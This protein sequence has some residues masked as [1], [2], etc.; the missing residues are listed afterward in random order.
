MTSWFPRT[1]P[2]RTA[3]RRR[4]RFVPW[5]ALL[6][7]FALA[8]AGRAADDWP[9][10]LGGAL[11]AYYA[12]DFA[13]ARRRGAEVAPDDAD[14]QREARLLEA[15]CELRSA[16][17]RNDALSARSRLAQLVR[18]DPGLGQRPECH[19]AY[20]VCQ[21]RL[22]ET[23]D[24]LDH[25]DRAVAGFQAAN[26]PA[27][28][29][30]AL[31]ATA[32]AW[33]VHG[34]WELL[35]PR[36]GAPPRPAPAEA[37]RIRRARMVETRAAAAQLPAGATAAAR[38]DVVIARYALA[39]GEHESAL[40][41]LE[42]LAAEAPRTVASTDAALLLAEQHEADARFA[43]ALPLYDRVAAGGAAAAAQLAGERAAEIRRPQCALN[44][45]RVVSTNAAADLQLRCR[46][47]ER[48][49]L[50]VRRIDL[51]SWLTERRG[52]FVESQL[53]TDG[54]VQLARSLVPQPAAPHAWWDAATLT[55]PV[56]VTA[57]AGAYVVTAQVHG[58]DGGRTTISRLL[59]VSDLRAT[60]FIGAREAVLWVTHAE[61]H[62]PPHPPRAEF[63]MHHSFVPTRPVFDGNGVAR[64]ALPAEARV[65]RDK[66]WACLVASGDHLAL[67]EGELGPR[68]SGAAE[69]RVALLGAPAAPAVGERFQ[70]VGLL[71][72]ERGPPSPPDGPAAVEIEV[73]DGL[74]RSYYRGAAAVTSADTFA[75]SVPIAPEM[76]GQDLRVVVRQAGQ[77]IEQVR[78]RF[79]FRVPAFDV[80]PLAASVRLPA[81]LPSDA[82]FL[83]GRVT[84]AYPWGTPAAGCS[85]ALAFRAVELTSTDW[86]A[87]GGA[88]PP[89]VMR[90]FLDE[91]GRFDFTFRL[92]DFPFASRPLAIGVWAH[93]EGWDER[94]A[95]AVA[96]TLAG[97]GPAFL[98][99]AAL[100]AVPAVGVPFQIRARWFDP[101]LLAAEPPRARLTEPDGR[102]HALRLFATPDG[103]RTA[104]WRPQRPGVHDVELMLTLRDGS[105]IGQRFAVEVAPAHDSTADADAVALSATRVPAETES[106]T[107]ADDAIEA[108]LQGGASGPLLLLAF[109]SEPWGAAVLPGVNGAATV[110]IPLAA[111]SADSVYVRVVR[112]TASGP[113]TLAE[114]MASDARD[115]D[116]ELRLDAVVCAAGPGEP[117][118]LSARCTRGDGTPAAASV[119]ARLMD[120]ADT[121]HVHWL[122]G[123]TRLAELAGASGVSAFGFGGAEPRPFGEP[124]ATGESAAAAARGDAGLE[125]SAALHEGGTL[126]L[127]HEQI[128]GEG[129]LRIERP[130]GAGPLRVVLIARDA[131]GRTAFATL[132]IDPAPGLSPRLALPARLTVGDRSTATLL[133]ENPKRE[134]ALV[135]VGLT[136][137]DTLH[138]DAV[139]AHALGRSIPV[140]AADGKWTLELPPAGRVALNVAVEAVR[141]GPSAL[142]AAI[143]CG[144]FTEVARARGDVHDP[145]PAAPAASVIRIRRTLL[146]MI[147]EYDPKLH[148]AAGGLTG[149][150]DP[151][152]RS[153][154]YE[155]LNSGDAIPVGSLIA[156]REDVSIIPPLSDPR[157]AAP[158]GPTW[159]QALP[160]CF[161]PVAPGS[162]PEHLIGRPGTPLLDRL[163]WRTDGLQPQEYRHE[164]AVIAV[165]P[166]VYQL[167]APQIVERGEA[168]GVALEPADLRIRVTDPQARDAP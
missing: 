25:L 29:A 125:L 142:R 116:A 126:A 120:A 77:V 130:A 165:R 7:A 35:D 94:A 60:G 168:L 146:R 110:H 38:I 119:V 67:C 154:S 9:P 107:S 122:P 4:S 21:T 87:G 37:D 86:L 18:D 69:P 137:S 63:W 109:G 30:A 44:V 93:V 89:I 15:L 10:E 144:A 134:R 97:D 22:F 70:L 62:P 6:V 160:P 98:A 166:G 5:G 91:A 159:S 129:T 71:W 1:F 123:Q 20:G 78:G 150:Y 156:V 65:L 68:A 47:V 48:I 80:T 133:L 8:D 39:A 59:L 127:A 49:D 161:V 163:D 45:P 135:T 41:T 152:R 167:A 157:F 13:E 23:A 73:L 106:N 111:P 46:N 17:G 162:V 151:L 148:D 64:F 81:R 139:R 57:A 11:A 61:A 95:Y 85:V 108:T 50:E 3:S 43:A 101:A 28:V 36:F 117:L 132:P 155:V 114:T 102:Q 118:T 92:T 51:Q 149:L 58:A 72:R 34:E 153:W 104:A 14:L 84:A 158:I 140:A 42:Q 90:G 75:T 105:T 145:S 138:V 79:S 115:P 24:A 12:D 88:S 113:H 16:V 33:A 19:L 112:L 76:A 143:E 128:A 82:A 99:G 96:K 31:V 147:A 136:P 40:L 55:E 27:R 74:G 83:S 103:P 124:T 54:G 131:A 164:Y 141:A 26:Q 100:P 2:A 52:R 32:E 53:R 121:G 56:R 66:R